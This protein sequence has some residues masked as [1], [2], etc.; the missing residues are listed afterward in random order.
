MDES[1]ENKIKTLFF[2]SVIEKVEKVELDEQR[3]GF[4]VDEKQ[5]VAETYKLLSET[6]VDITLLNKL[7][8]YH[9]ESINAIILIFNEIVNPDAN[10]ESLPTEA[11]AALAEPALAEVDLEL[12]PHTHA[13]PVP[14]NNILTAIKHHK[15]I[16][17][18]NTKI[19]EMINILRTNSS[20]ISAFVKVVD[21]KLSIIRQKY[22]ERR[23]SNDGNAG[24]GTPPVLK[25][26]VDELVY[27]AQLVNPTI[28]AIVSPPPISCLSRALGYSTVVSSGFGAVSGICLACQCDKTCFCLY[29]FIASVACCAA[30]LICL[31][32]IGANSRLIGDINVIAGDNV[33]E[34]GNDVPVA[35]QAINRGGRSTHKKRRFHKKHISKKYKKRHSSKRKRR[36]KKSKVL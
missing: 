12:P 35:A 13:V 27:A 24:G 28:N 6:S 29:P 1:L 34:G 22:L 32:A 23:R 8:S 30:S 5:T 9:V 20:K 19:E 21:D 3:R 4:K 2:F 10:L 18:I 11:E 16:K 31:N 26:D 15:A 7:I 33:V 17:V 25:R 36:S 14:R